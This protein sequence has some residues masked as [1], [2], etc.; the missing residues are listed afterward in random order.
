[1]VLVYLDQVLLASTDRKASDPL[2][3]SQN[4]VHV[5]LRRINGHW[6]VDDIEPF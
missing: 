6:L 1:V 3:V 2:K 4:R 5:T